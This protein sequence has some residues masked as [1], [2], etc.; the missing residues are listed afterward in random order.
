MK[1]YSYYIDD[2]DYPTDKVYFEVINNTGDIDS[3]IKII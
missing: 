2:Y 3:S 1:C